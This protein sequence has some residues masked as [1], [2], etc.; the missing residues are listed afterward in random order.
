M[1][2]PFAVSAHRM[3]GK[4]L[5]RY[6]HGNDPNPAPLDPSF[7]GCAD[8]EQTT[9][10]PSD[11]D[12]QARRLSRGTG[13][14]APAAFHFEVYGRFERLITQMYFPTSRSMLR[15]ATLRRTAA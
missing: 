15:P 10:A 6:A 13:L 5:R 2:N 14:D 4:H 9:T 3:A 7:V 1:A 12:R 11:Q 8:I